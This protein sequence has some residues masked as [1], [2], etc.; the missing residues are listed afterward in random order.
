[1]TDLLDVILPVFLVIGF[2][3][4]MARARLIGSD[5]I[6]GIMK[7]AQ[8]FA[9]PCLL[10][11]SVA[12]LDLSAAYDAGLMISFY[13]GAFSGF[14]AGFFGA[15][16]IFNRPLTDA[17]AIGFACLF[18]NSLLLGLAITERK[19]GPDA[20]A[21]NFAIISIHSPLLYAVGITMM[22]L[23]RS[24]GQGL[25]ATQLAT[26]VGRAIFSQPLVIGI[27]CGF[28]VNLSGQALPGF[29]M[30]AVEM[31]TRA[32]IPAALFSLGGVLI[33]Y[34]PEGDKLTIAMV[35]AISLILHPAIV[36]V[37]ARFVFGLDTAGLR[38]AVMTAAMAPGVN[39]YMFASIYGVAMRVAASAVLV[40]TAL[41]IFTV[42]GWLQI[43]P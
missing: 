31:M 36:Y 40:A 28:A 1:M 8:N 13:V 17:V 26:K 4:A 7:F 25:A 34:R 3:Y 38:S 32:A 2:G 18:S 14:A 6:D 42:W 30:A 20:L 39:A 19:Y 5:G 37:L 27:L 29:M 12:T 35:C 43:L 11:K 41:S 16:L 21:G 24:K 10:F 22:E 33:R 9:L 15:R 23:A